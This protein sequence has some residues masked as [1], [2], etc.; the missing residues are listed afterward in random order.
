MKVTNKTTTY[1]CFVF[2]VNFR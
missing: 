2:L 1:Y